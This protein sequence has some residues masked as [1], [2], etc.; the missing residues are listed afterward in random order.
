MATRLINAIG[1]GLGQTVK[2]AAKSAASRL[3]DAAT[4]DLPNTKSFYNLGMGVGPFIRNTVQS[5]QKDSSSNASDTKKITASL[6]F[7]KENVVTQ[8][9]ISGQLSALTSIMSDIRKISLAQLNLQRA[10]MPRGAKGFGDRSGYLS[11]EQK[12]EGGDGGGGSGRASLSGT[13]STPQKGGDKLFGGL[14]SFMGNNPLISA[15]LLGGLYLKFKEDIDKFLEDSKLAP[16][17]RDLYDRVKNEVIENVKAG[18]S[19]VAESIKEQFN[20]GLKKLKNDPASAITPGATLGGA[21]AGRVLASKIPLLR[22]VPGFKLGATVLGGVLGYNEGASVEQL[23][24]NANM[25]ART[26]EEKAAKEAAKAKLTDMG[27]DLAGGAVSLYGAKKIYDIGK[28]LISGQPSPSVTPTAPPGGTTP[29]PGGGGR[30]PMNAKTIADGSYEA[31]RRSRAPVTGGG[32]PYAAAEANKPSILRR[33]L[34]SLGDYAVKTKEMMV[35]IYANLAKAISKIGMQKVVAYIGMRAGV[36]ATGLAGGPVVIVTTVLSVGWTVYDLYGFVSDL[37]KDIDGKDSKEQDGEKDAGKDNTSSGANPQ[38]SPSAT[39]S[40][41]SSALASP[42]AGRDALA[43]SSGYGMRKDPFTGEDK[44]HKG[45]DYTAVLGTP[46]NAINDG[47]IIEVGDDDPKNKGT[48]LG[49]FVKIMHEDGTISVYGHMSEQSAV[50]GKRIKKGDVIGKVGS[51]GRSTGPHLH[52]E[53]HKPNEKGVFA[54]IDPGKYFNN[55]SSS[56][57]SNVNGASN[58]SAPGAASAA[59]KPSDK[60]ASVFGF[61]PSKLGVDLSKELSGSELA[62]LNSLYNDVTGVQN[63]MGDAVKEINKTQQ[64]SNNRTS[65]PAPVQTA[66]STQAKEKEYLW[67]HH[68]PAPQLYYAA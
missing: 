29:P 3:K 25:E 66:G 19:S 62:Q 21:V 64:L 35:K 30:V 7:A 40:P 50:R 68:N 58:S 6:G 11:L 59:S 45:Y 67:H 22:R 34:G 5:Y 38:T 12:L 15:G 39:Q 18:I 24:R 36:A 2:G 37:M 41:G 61:D 27:L 55:I 47:E 20:I 53:I 4:R 14:L 16:L 32:N 52:L 28:G 9:N 43:P 57:N 49:K 60:F 31:S 17:F 26:P 54:P 65:A 42:I 48:G 51:S 33:A 63:V 1:K 13:P 46:I 23:V 10:S 44:M 56:N 8:K